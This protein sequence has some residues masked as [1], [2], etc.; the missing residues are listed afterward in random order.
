MKFHSARKRGTILIVSIWVIMLLAAMA[1]VFAHTMRIETLANSN[2]IYQV[3]SRELANG[4][5]AYAQALASDA[6]D[7]ELAEDPQAMGDD[8]IVLI[9]N[10]VDQ[11]NDIAYGMI[12]EAAKVNLNRATQ[13]MLAK[14]P[15]MNEDLAAIII[16]WR[17]GN[18]ELTPNGAEDEYYLMLDEPYTAKN[19]ALESIDELL[20]LKDF[21]RSIIYGEDTNRNTI[22]DPNENDGDES[23]PPDNADGTLNM[24]LFPYV[25]TYSVESNQVKGKN[26]PNVNSEGN[27]SAVLAILQKHLSS[28][29]SAVVMNN[30]KTSRQHSS[31]ID[32]FYKSQ[33]T[34][35]EFNLVANDLT[36]RNRPNISGRI[37]INAAPRKV[38]MCLPELEESDVDKIIAYRKSKSDDDLT[39]VGWITEALGDDGKE[40]AIG[41]GSYITVKS[42]QYAFDALVVR[43]GGKS[44]A[45]RYIVVDTR[46]GVQ[47]KLTQDLTWLGWPLE[48]KVLTQLQSDDND[49]PQ[50]I[51]SDESIR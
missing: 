15:G 32:L 28:S 43:K 45:R 10:D 39:T 26:K 25:T 23:D 18:I 16:D 36:T 38:L 17:D 12:D 41:I 50:D 8:W 49:D 11:D 33:M 20:L 9:K 1:L 5:I 6:I 34:L 19:G 46:N 27:N 51:L 47:I 42:S 30:I 22:L 14:L 21:T 13:D 31:L 37:N 3:Q 29:R 7:K 2:R 24:G 4:A 48:Q 35:K 44:Y 40:K